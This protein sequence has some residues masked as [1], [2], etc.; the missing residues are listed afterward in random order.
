MF[1][2]SGIRDESNSAV[3]SQW[4][5]EHEDEFTFGDSADLNGIL[6]Y[7]PPLTRKPKF[8]LPTFLLE[9]FINE[10][11]IAMHTAHSATQIVQWISDNYWWI[12]THK[13]KPTQQHVVKQWNELCT[14]DQ[15]RRIRRALPQT[16]T[17]PWD[18]DRDLK[19]QKN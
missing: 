10:V 15:I 9:I 2:H 14:V 19:K 16:R 6:F 4:V 1:K 13:S 8:V 5:M 11:D 17:T 3:V 18:P 12:A 7:V